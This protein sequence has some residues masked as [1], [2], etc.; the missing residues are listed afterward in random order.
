L[1]KNGEKITYK[2]KYENQNNQTIKNISFRLNSG[3]IGL[4]LSSVEIL[5]T[6]K[7]VKLE[8]NTIKIED[9]VPGEG[10]ELEL[11][12][13]FDRRQVVANQEALLVTDIEYQ[14]NN[15]TIKY[16]A[17]SSKIKIISDVLADVSARY[18]SQ[19]GDQL[20]V[21]P[22]P[23]AVDMATNYWLFLEFNNSG[24]DLKDFIL[25]AELPDN[26]YFSG[27]KRVLDGNLNYAEIGKRII[28][29]ISEIEG[30]TGKYRANLEIILIPGQ[31]DLGKVIDLVKNIKFTAYDQFVQ[32]E[33]SGVLKDINTNIE[34][35]RFSSG[36]GS[37]RILK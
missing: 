35:D 17:Y 26:V 36:K 1:F 37:V 23:P 6:P 22:L 9:L 5:N 8:G 14:I 13:L 34:K 12:V 16:T 11:L 27:N 18:Y 10:E 30:G 31:D 21:G 24:N 15:Q 33:I 32:E 25:T 20:G 19:Q 7:N 28:W 29:E 2:I 4:F 3:Q